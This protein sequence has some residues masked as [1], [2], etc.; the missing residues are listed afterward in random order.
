MASRTTAV[1]AKWVRNVALVYELHEFIDDG[2]IFE[3]F[4]GNNN[5]QGIPI[6]QTS[7]IRDKRNLYV[8]RHI[9]WRCVCVATRAMYLHD[10]GKV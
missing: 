5:S 7:R 3:K 6:E 10:P 8:K 1:R 9:M 4:S 2:Q